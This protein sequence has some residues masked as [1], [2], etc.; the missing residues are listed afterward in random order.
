MH[1]NKH[2]VRPKRQ[3][4]NTKSDIKGNLANT[5]SDTKGNLANTNGSLANTKS[6][7]KWQ[8]NI[9]KCNLSKSFKHRDAQQDL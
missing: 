1:F 7:K 5:K 4:A 6:D 8:F 2:I 3:L 9:I